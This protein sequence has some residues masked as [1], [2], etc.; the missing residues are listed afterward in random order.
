MAGLN[1]WLTDFLI[2]T[3][4]EPTKPTKQVMKVLKVA[5]KGISTEKDRIKQQGKRDAIAF[6]EE[7]ANQ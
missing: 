2:C 6:F 7:N 1:K 3:S 4:N 5:T